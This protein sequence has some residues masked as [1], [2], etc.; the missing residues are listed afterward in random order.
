MGSHCH[1]LIGDVKGVR[2]VPPP[3]DQCLYQDYIGRTLRNQV[4]DRLKTSV[5]YQ[6]LRVVRQGPVPRRDA[7]GATSTY[8]RGQDLQKDEK[9]A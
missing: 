1:L 8:E 7:T 2:S 9:R 6:G 4:N 5:T 3:L